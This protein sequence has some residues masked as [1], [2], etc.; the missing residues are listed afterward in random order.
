MMYKS[1][2][3]FLTPSGSNKCV[4]P[5]HMLS[6]A[7]KIILHTLCSCTIYNVVQILCKIEVLEVGYMF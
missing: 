1:F 3:V 4:S 6:R 5:T 7:M 2:G